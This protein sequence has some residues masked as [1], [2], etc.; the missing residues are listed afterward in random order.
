M[1]KLNV[2][3]SWHVDK[4]ILRYFSNRLWHDAPDEADVEVEADVVA[5]SSLQILFY[6][7]N[8]FGEFHMLY[9]SPSFTLKLKYPTHL[10]HVYNIL[11]FLQY[12][13]TKRFSG[14]LP[15]TYLKAI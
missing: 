3:L 9:F 15:C 1:M 11:A 13:I 12:L 8:R 10:E 4:D 5:K 2:K 6:E 7:M 14:P